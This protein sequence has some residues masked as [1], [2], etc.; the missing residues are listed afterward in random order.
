[1]TAVV[2]PGQL[3]PPLSRFETGDPSIGQIAE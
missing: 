2:H 1:V 3:S